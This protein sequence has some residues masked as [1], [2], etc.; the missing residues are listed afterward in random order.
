MTLGC[1]A[2]LPIKRLGH[3]LKEEGYNQRL[4][5]TKSPLGGTK[6]LTLYT[7]AKLN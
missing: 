6:D 4:A 5:K 2:V 1:V 3:R 7:D